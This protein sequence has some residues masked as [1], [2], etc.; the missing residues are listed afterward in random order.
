M[1]NFKY[2]P[3]EFI[4]PL[5]R[6]YMPTI[7][8]LV[9][10]L[11]TIMADLNLVVDN[12]LLRIYCSEFNKDVSG[13]ESNGGMTPKMTMVLKK[14]VYDNI[15]SRMTDYV[16]LLEDVVFKSGKYEWNV[17][18][19][20]AAKNSIS[21]V[22]I[23][24]SVNYAADI[25]DP[26][27]RLKYTLMENINSG[28]GRRSGMSGDP[29]MRNVS[30]QEMTRFIEIIRDKLSD[31][32]DMASD[33]DRIAKDTSTKIREVADYIMTLYLI[34]TYGVG[35]FNMKDSLTYLNYSDASKY[36]HHIKKMSHLQLSSAVCVYPGM[37][38]NITPPED[39]SRSHEYDE[40]YKFLC[41]AVQYHV[42]RESIYKEINRAD[43]TTDTEP[44]GACS[45]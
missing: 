30:E 37:T 31:I 35:S 8:P 11:C 36:K 39:Q 23:A 4:E 13:F 15:I 20:A 12:N 6:S 44:A 34:L 40:S 22:I 9:Y 7:M 2:I 17:V 26:I 29:G 41:I 16:N 10:H 19:P 33:R 27:L 43:Q 14:F 5:S 21:D 38:L 45:D 18:A 42:I 3:S 32:Y 28:H 25:V 1:I 24:N